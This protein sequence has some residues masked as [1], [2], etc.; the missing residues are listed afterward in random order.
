MLS[1][2]LFFFN[3][4]TCKGSIHSYYLEYTDVNLCT[5]MQMLCEDCSPFLEIVKKIRSLGLAILKGGTEVYDGKILIYY[6][7]EV[8]FLRCALATS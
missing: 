4:C 3:L 6:V 8:L 5:C 2:S 7:V 1:S